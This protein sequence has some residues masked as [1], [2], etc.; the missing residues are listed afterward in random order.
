[1]KHLYIIILIALVPKL[2]FC[3]SEY[4]ATDS[5]SSYGIELLDGRDYINSQLCQVKL[6][7]KIIQY[8]PYEINEYGF[9]DGRVYISKE[10]YIADSL[11]TVFLERVHNGETILYYY[12]EKGI[13]TFF[14]QKDSTFF[15]EMP[16][17]NNKQE[18]YSTQ[19]L[20]LT[21]D[22]PNVLDA[23][24]LVRYNKR[25]LSK[26]FSR[27][28]QC[29]LKPFPHFKY[30]FL[31]AYEFLKL[32]P[33][34]EAYNDLKDFDYNY[35]GGFS[36]GLFIDN[37]I[38]V[39]DFS[40][41]AEILFS[42]HGYSYNKLVD[43]KDLD[44]VAN[45]TSVNVP[46]LLRYAYPS[47]KIRPFI[48]VGI[49]GA[50]FIKNETLLY[51]TTINETTIEISDTE[52]TSMI[53]DIQLAYVVGGGLEYKLNYK[54]SL[55]FELRYNAPFYQGDYELLGSSAISVLTGINF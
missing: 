44:F 8:T 28:N 32:I 54:K 16:E 18:D 48:N 35:D 17:R 22:C 41:H 14:I 46:L 9:K 39:T 12:A 2:S 43:N 6:G 37:P 55:F 1:M 30:G 25:S 34:D 4:F 53:S 50:Y 15:V 42:K 40:L 10:I 24:K 45:F 31:F 51:K 33:A 52:I 23:C 21:K 26:L 11:K 27:Y 49:N 36:V 29:A 20:N 5:T 19:L 38:F 13:K 47:N 7:D 3:Q